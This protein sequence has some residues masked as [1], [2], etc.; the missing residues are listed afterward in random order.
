[1]NLS[2]EEHKLSVHSRDLSYQSLKKEEPNTK[3]TETTNKKRQSRSYTPDF[4]VV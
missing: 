3:E 1:M 2:G 4:S